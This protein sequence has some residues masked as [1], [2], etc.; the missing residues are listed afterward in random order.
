VNHAACK[1]LG[2]QKG[3]LVGKPF[4]KLC[5]SESRKKMQE[6]FLSWKKKMSIQKEDLTIQTK[7]GKKFTLLTHIN[8]VKNALSPS[9]FFL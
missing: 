2:Y 1:A 7:R 9:F 3:E 5:V 6:L 4:Y 8:M